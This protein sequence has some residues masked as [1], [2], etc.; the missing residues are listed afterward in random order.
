MDSGILDL[1]TYRDPNLVETLRIYDGAS[2]SL[3]EDILS[4]ETLPPEATET[5]IGTIGA[6]D[7]SAP[8]PYQ[9]GWDSL[10]QYLRRE[11]SEMRQTW[12]DQVLGTT[13]DDFLNFSARLSNM[14]DASIA[15]VSS[16][17]AIDDAQSQGVDLQPVL[18]SQ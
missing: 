8:Q 2:A 9:L 15:V 5:I 14:A 1:V 13:R 18:L 12:R 16:Q 7:G 4:S 17:A 6:L 3:T 11:T 10:R